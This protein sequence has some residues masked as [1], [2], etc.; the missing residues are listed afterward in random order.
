MFRNVALASKKKKTFQVLTF[1]DGLNLAL[2]N[3][4]N[5][6]RNIM[7]ISLLIFK[8]TLQLKKR[9]NEILKSTRWYKPKH[10]HITTNVVGWGS[11][12]GDTC[13]FFILPFE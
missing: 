12:L 8:K 11:F 6:L 1:L 3:P 10:I 5:I 13:L 7:I 9:H 4:P 2:L